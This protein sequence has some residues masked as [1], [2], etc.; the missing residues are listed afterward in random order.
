V[1]LGIGANL[2]VQGF[3]AACSHP[4]LQFRRLKAWCRCSHGTTSINVVAS[5]L[6]ARRAI[7]LNPFNSSRDAG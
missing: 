3:F 6:P 2:A 5:I 7:M 1:A 4:S